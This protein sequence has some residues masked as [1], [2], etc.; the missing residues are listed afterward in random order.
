M[1][2]RKKKRTRFTCTLEDSPASFDSQERPR[3]NSATSWYFPVLQS[4]IQN[5]ILLNVSIFLLLFVQKET[6]KKYKNWQLTL[7]ALIFE[8]NSLYQTKRLEFLHR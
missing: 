7:D 5:T 4:R 8:V 6:T 2:Y 1:L 3:S